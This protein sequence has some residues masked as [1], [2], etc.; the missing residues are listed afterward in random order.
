M[1]LPAAYLLGDQNFEWNIKPVCW[2]HIDPGWCGGGVR[3]YRILQ[4]PRSLSTTLAFAPPKPLSAFAIFWASSSLT[5]DSSR[6]LSSCCG[7]LFLFLAVCR[8]VDCWNFLSPVTLLPPC[9]S[10]LR[11]LPL[12]FPSA[13]IS[14]SQPPLPLSSPYRYTPSP[15]SQSLAL[16]QVLWVTS[17]FIAFFKASLWGRALVSLYPG[18]RVFQTSENVLLQS[19]AMYCEMSLSIILS[20]MASPLPVTTSLIVSISQTTRPCYQELPSASYSPK[21]LGKIIIL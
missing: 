6:S 15:R 3:L 2:R 13:S 16:L 14:S 9:P 8:D 5:Y 4:I 11:P 20:S 19:A 21:L 7:F 12:L 18:T 10:T 1:K 17:Y